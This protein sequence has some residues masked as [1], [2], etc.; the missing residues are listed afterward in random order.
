MA[1]T[2][3][4][5]SGHNNGIMDII[6]NGGVHSGSSYIVFGGTGISWPSYATATKITTLTNATSPAVT[7]LQSV[8]NAGFEDSIA[9]TTGDVNGDGINDVIFGEPD[10]GAGNSGKGEIF[11]Y[12][13]HPNAGRWRPILSPTPRPI[14]GHRP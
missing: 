6:I 14:S 2:A 10:T 12:F 11:V 4:D 3:A 13:G 7:K 5:V 1:V 9:V 8:I